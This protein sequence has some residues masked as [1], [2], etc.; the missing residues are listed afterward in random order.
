MVWSFFVKDL[1]EDYE[2]LAKR[3]PNVGCLFFVGLVHYGLVF[4]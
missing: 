1:E 4:D 3:S 2:M